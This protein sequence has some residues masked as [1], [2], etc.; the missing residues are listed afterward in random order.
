MLKFTI[1]R[2][3]KVSLILCLLV[4]IICTVMLG[5]A[6][7]VSSANHS[8]H[9]RFPFEELSQ[10]NSAE[11]AEAKAQAALIRDFPLGTRPSKVVRYL[12]DSGAKCET[13]QKVKGEILCSYEHTQWGSILGILPAPLTYEWKI[14]IKTDDEKNE[15]RDYRVGAGLTGL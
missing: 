2:R 14:L 3:L 9:T 8:E 10:S 5:V 1:P 13:L 7:C 4:T 11:D 12:S 15:V 6:S